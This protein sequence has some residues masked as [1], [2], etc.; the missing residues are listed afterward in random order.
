MLKAIKVALEIVIEVV[1]L[2]LES[3]LILKV[4]DLHT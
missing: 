4:P 1:T 2:K 3:R